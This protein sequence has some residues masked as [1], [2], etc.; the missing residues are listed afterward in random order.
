M[1]WALNMSMK[2]RVVDIYFE[3]LE[4]KIYVW[5]MDTMTKNRVQ[6]SSISNIYILMWP[7]DRND[8]SMMSNTL[9]IYLY[10]YLIFAYPR[11]CLHHQCTQ[12]VVGCSARTKYFSISRKRG[13]NEVIIGGGIGSVRIL[14][15]SWMCKTFHTS[16]VSFKF[17]STNYCIV[18]SL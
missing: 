13:M 5:F 9:N 15:Y 16:N 7:F 18:V 6:Q 11:L 3:P 1:K 17:P 10:I 12:H 8:L 4:H 14:R 2:G